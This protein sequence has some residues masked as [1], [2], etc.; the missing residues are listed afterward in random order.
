MDDPLRQHLREGHGLHEATEGAVHTDDMTMYGSGLGPAEL[1]EL[2]H[3]HH[4]E[5]ADLLR[6]SHSDDGG[7]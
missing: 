6:H 7:G 4:D 2:H 1:V 5:H 3:Q